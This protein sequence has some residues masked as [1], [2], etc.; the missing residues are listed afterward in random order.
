MHTV[1][2]LGQICYAPSE[3]NVQPSTLSDQGY[4]CSLRPKKKYVCLL[5]D[6]NLKQGR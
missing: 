6:E 2:L 1:C 5:F 4:L 3:D